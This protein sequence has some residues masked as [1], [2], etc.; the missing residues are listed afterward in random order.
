MF[1]FVPVGRFHGISVMT[2]YPGTEL[3]KH[4]NQELVRIRIMK[5]MLMIYMDGAGTCNVR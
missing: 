3:S 5:Q 1:I 4:T 2:H